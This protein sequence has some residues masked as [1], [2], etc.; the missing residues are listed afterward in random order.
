MTVTPLPEDPDVTVAPT[1]LTF[2]P[3]DYSRERTFLVSAA[4]DDDDQDDVSLVRHTASGGGYDAVHIPTVVVT[5]ID[6]TTTTP[7]VSARASTSTMP[8]GGAVVLD[9]TASDPQNNALTYVWTSDGGGTFTNDRALHTVWTAPAAGVGDREVTLT[10]T[11]T[12]TAGASATATV[13]V[14]VLGNAPPRPIIT[15]GGG[16]GGGGPSG[17]TPSDEDF[18]WNVT[19]DIEE[20]ASG[21]DVPTGLW[22][23]GATLWLAENGP[24]AD[25]A[26]YAYDLE[27]GERVEEREFELDSDN[28]TPRGVWSDRSTIWISDSGKEKLFAHDLESGERLPDSDLALHPD[29]DDPRGIW[30]DDSTMWVL[31][32]RDN[33]LFAYDLASG[34]LLAEYALDDD[35]GDPRGLWSDGTSAWVSDDRA[36]RLFAYRLPSIED[37]ASEDEDLELERVRDEEFWKLSRAS[38]NSPRGLWS[39][40]DVMYVADASDGKVYSYNMP[41]AID[42]RLASF[43]LSG[44][45]FGE[46][47]SAQAEYTGVA[48]DGVTET[49]VGAEA[50]QSGAAV[51][52]KPDDDDGDPENGHQVAL[53]EVSEITVTV[54]SAD[55][56]RERVYRVLVG[57]PAQEAPCFRGAVALGFSL[58]VYA[59]GSVEELVDCAQSRHGT[60]LYTLHDGGYVPY[61]L[62]VPEFVNSS[63]GELF[64]GGVPASTPLIIKSEGPPTA[65]P[66]GS[67]TGEDRTPP[68]PECLRGTVATGFS[69]VLYQGGVIEELVAC[70]ESRDITAIYALDEGGYFPYILGAPEFVNRAFR[71]LFTGGLPAT[72]PLIVKSD[73]VSAAG[74]TAGAP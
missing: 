53:E 15:G 61:I 12:D 59:G 71:E 4:A 13:V 33:A 58:V 16:G 52:I 30:S 68:W 20:L 42:A 9:G 19:R 6:T 45:D 50:A 56:S 43:T 21:H 25:D 64:A 48:D 8:G 29:N 18:E 46:F 7:T 17:P 60:A 23:D 27:S 1:T 62:G 73:G 32:S 14:T 54:T 69:L 22:S 67:I 2:T 26:I 65:D 47:D 41:D 49:T 37:D 51:V 34:E 24:G 28:R 44:V 31:D 11:V 40:G 3:Q 38:N 39:D 57:D 5:V 63:F 70:A 10:L 66:A 74:A 72:S 55:E 35:N 36:N